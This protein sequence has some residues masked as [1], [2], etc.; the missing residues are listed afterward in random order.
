MTEYLDK[1]G[2]QYF[3]NKINTKI[4]NEID[5]QVRLEAAERSSSD[6]SLSARIDS[7]TSLASGSTTGDAELTDVRVGFDGSRYPNAGDAVRGQVYD[8]SEAIG[9]NKY[10]SSNNIL[11]TRRAIGGR[12]S[13]FNGEIFYIGPGRKLSDVPKNNITL[14]LEFQDAS[15]PVGEQ[16]N[17][18]YSDG[19]I[20]NVDYNVG[21]LVGKTSIAN[22]TN[23]VGI[24]IKT[25][26]TA[27]TSPITKF[28]IVYNSDTLDLY[29]LYYYSS[30]LKYY[31]SYEHH[32]VPFE[33]QNGVLGTD[34]LYNAGDSS[35]KH[36]IVPVKAG[37]VYFI[38]GYSFP[39][40]MYPAYFCLWGNGNGWDLKHGEAGLGKKIAEKIV[41]PNGCNYLVVNTM[42]NVC[43][44]VIQKCVPISA[45]DYSEASYWKNKKIVWF[46]TSIPAGVVHGNSYPSLI[47]EKLGA[48][49]YN[50]SIGSSEVR[51]GVHSAITVDDPMGWSAMSAP[52]LLLSLSLS[53]AEKQ[54]IINNWESK[55]KYI[56]TWYGDRVDIDGQ[57]SRYLNSSWD[58]ILP[59]YLTGGSVGQCDLYVFDHGY[60]DGVKDLGFTDLSDEPE[61]QTDRTYWIGAMG[62]IFKKILDDNPRARILIVGHYN[63]DASAGTVSQTKYVCEAQKK[64]AEEWHYPIIKTW[65]HMGFSHKNVNYNGSEIPISQVWMPDD[66]HPHSDSSGKAIDH[67]ANILYP[68]I[69][70][71]R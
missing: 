49:V 63:T 54:E 53:S 34:N 69:K 10:V 14:K 3:Y 7:F 67:Y 57:S 6:F 43:D 4:N 15:T 60:N 2:L 30:E 35:F 26:S 9:F 41:I 40:P 18:V 71:I 68:M 31:G 27:N 39:S 19:T 33:L 58:V 32:S 47:G 56:V 44:I 21:V 52:G 24:R 70:E 5:R 64:L 25:Y 11:D 66:V 8:L 17:F 37:D 62:Y 16:Y 61:N 50:E 59:K 12:I 55:W 38:T 23:V 48:I 29:E 51:G 65:E 42:T 46:G 36:A 20:G 1:N 13:N 22:Y 28:G 45:E